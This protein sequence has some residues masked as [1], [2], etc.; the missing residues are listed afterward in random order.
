VA[1]SS[2]A[3]RSTAENQRTSEV[4]VPFGWIIAGFGSPGLN[5]W[6]GFSDIRDSPVQAAPVIIA[7]L[8][9]H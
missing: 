4:L 3:F 1:L 8:A 6:S 5:Y 7:R 9:T 2:I